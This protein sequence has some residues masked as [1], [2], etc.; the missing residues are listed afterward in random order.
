MIIGG[1]AGIAASIAVTRGVAVQDVPLDA[2]NAALRA[3]GQLV[4]LPSGSAAT[5]AGGG[6]SA[7]A[8]A[9]AERPLAP[10]TCSS[11]PDLTTVAQ[12]LT[13]P[14]LSPGPP[15]PGRRTRMQLGGMWT[16]RPAYAILYTPP[17]WPERVATASAGSTASADSAATGSANSADSAATGSA[18]SAATGSADSAATGSAGRTTGAD[19][20]PSQPERLPIIIELPGNGGFHDHFGDVCTGL[21]ENSSLGFGLS[22]GEG[23]LWAAVPF[24]HTNYSLAK[25]W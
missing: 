12:D 2:L 20:A 6:G 18:D 4:D 25:Q 5:A 17:E 9:T 8:A 21:P 11:L 13:V 7:T 3:A 19:S 15:R 10:T 14:P 16:S 22:G 24:L 1:A 23:A